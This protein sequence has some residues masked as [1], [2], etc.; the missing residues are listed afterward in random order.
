MEEKERKSISPDDTSPTKHVNGGPVTLDPT[1]KDGSAKK[2][3]S[4]GGGFAGLA[5]ML[6]T[7][8][9]GQEGTAVDSKRQ[10]GCE[11]DLPLGTEADSLQINNS[12][13]LDSGKQDA[14]ERHQGVMGWQSFSSDVSNHTSAS[15][16]S[17]ELLLNERQLDPE[18]MLA[19]L[20]FGLETEGFVPSLARI[21]E[22][23]LRQPS[24]ATG[25]SLPGVGEDVGADIFEEAPQA[26][27]SGPTS[28]ESAPIPIP[29]APR[30][31]P[32]GLYFLGLYFCSCEGYI[33]MISLLLKGVPSYF[34]NEEGSK[35]YKTYRVSKTEVS[36][37]RKHK[38]KVSSNSGVTAINSDIESIDNKFQKPER[39]SFVQ[40]ENIIP[41]QSH[42]VKDHFAG[43]QRSNQ[44]SPSTLENHRNTFQSDVCSK[45]KSLIAAL[46]DLK[47]DNVGPESFTVSTSDLST[48]IMNAGQRTEILHCPETNVFTSS[49]PNICQQIEARNHDTSKTLKRNQSSPEITSSKR[50]SEKGFRNSHQRSEKQTAHG[51]NNSQSTYPSQKKVGKFLDVSSVKK[52]AK[53]IGSAISGKIYKKLGISGKDG[54]Q[55]QA[56]LP[57]SSA[58]DSGPRPKFTDYS[59]LTSKLHVAPLISN[60]RLPGQIVAVSQGN[61]SSHSNTSKTK[62]EVTKANELTNK[63]DESHQNKRYVIDNAPRSIDMARSVDRDANHSDSFKTETIVRVNPSVAKYDIKCV[64]TNLN[65]QPSEEPFLNNEKTSEANIRDDKFSESNYNV[66][67]ADINSRINTFDA[68]EVLDTDHLHDYAESLTVDRKRADSDLEAERNDASGA[69]PLL[70]CDPPKDISSEQTPSVDVHVDSSFRKSVRFL[71]DHH[72]QA[73]EEERNYLD[74]EASAEYLLESECLN[75]TPKHDFTADRIQDSVPSPHYFPIIDSSFECK[76]TE[77]RDLSKYDFYDDPFDNCQL[78]FT[79]LKSTV[80]QFQDFVLDESET[81][82]VSC[83]NNELNLLRNTNSGI[84]ASDW[85]QFTP[86]V[87]KHSQSMRIPKLTVTPL[88]RRVSLG[89]F[90]HINKPDSSESSLSWF[91]LTP[92]AANF[93]KLS[94]KDKEEI[95]ESNVSTSSSDSEEDTSSTAETYPN[96]ETLV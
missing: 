20:G 92:S 7:K 75:L 83:N 19:S 74:D 95:D 93:D 27:L 9:K 53:N 24:K 26:T 58:A 61:A 15:S 82:E 47:S 5:R 59:H 96:T 41:D 29:A 4:G 45:D 76:N 62:T 30:K 89:S 73:V 56:R 32:G 64:D 11:D 2:S 23:F 65:D 69:N 57:H 35:C 86:A 34:F 48:N 55:S 3:G 13:H 16:A 78:E 39:A 77:Q 81:G 46:Y 40:K 18:I 90:R 14:Y 21:P 44:M 60:V 80:S 37:D 67:T 52:A 12:Q 36:Q 68:N 33:D 38:A 22:R 70:V 51:Q 43:L 84:I 85:S 71:Y 17:L 66:E 1:S 8:A 54:A 72:L 63:F 31:R 28:S 25:I 50:S 91:H 87:I 79:D 42:G 49:T 10:K 88:V 94:D 6:G